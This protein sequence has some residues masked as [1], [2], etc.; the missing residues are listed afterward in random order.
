MTDYKGNA[1]DTAVGSILSGRRPASLAR[2]RYQ[3][4]QLIKDKDRWIVR[5]REDVR[6]RLADGEKPRKTD[7]VLGDGYVQRRIRRK[8][9]IAA[10]ADTTKPMAKRLLADLLA[11]INSASYKPVVVETFAVFAEKWISKVLTETKDSNQRSDKSIIRKHLVKAFGDCQLRDITTEALQDWISRHTK[12]PKTIKNHI[13]TFKSMWATAKAWGRVHDDPFEGLKLPTVVKG[14]GTYFFSL[15]EMLAIV[16][17]ANGWKR[18]FFGIM[19]ETAMRPGEL[20][21][22]R[23][24]DVQGRVLF[25][26]QSVW[27]RKVQTPKT[28]GS[29][30]VCTVSL[31]CAELLAKHLEET[32]DRKNVEGLVFTSET[33]R[34]LSMDNFRHRTLDP[35]LKKLGIKAKIKAAGVRGGNY[36][37]RHG[38][39]TALSRAGTP[40][41][42]IQ[43]RTGHVPGSRVTQEHYLH[44]LPADDVAAADY[45][46]GLVWPMSEGEALQ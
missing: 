32:K 15:E 13:T 44:A 1:T 12:S 14:G 24:E 8:K 28:P 30:R 34:P 20:A 10:T 2:T 45:M 23:R 29:V 19:A 36:A 38:N 26:R 31:R 25:V 9:P 42:T 7:I 4:G 18:L 17:A 5:W 27:Q 11:P 22:L 43:E 33:G 3:D 6:L 35:I 41:K 21:G 37:F 46:G 16:N 39:M 40:L